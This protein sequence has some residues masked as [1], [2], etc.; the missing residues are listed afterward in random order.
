MEQIKSSSR[1]VPSLYFEPILVLNTCSR[2]AVALRLVAALVTSPHLHIEPFA[3]QVHTAAQRLSRAPRARPCLRQIMPA[4]ITCIVCKALWGAKER[5]AALRPSARPLVR[6]N[7]NSNRKPVSLTLS[8][9]LRCSCRYIR[10]SAVVLVVRILKRWR[11]LPH[12][13][14]RTM[15]T[16]LHA[17]PD[18]SKVPPCRCRPCTCA[19]SSGAALSLHLT[20]FLQPF[21]THFGALSA[22]STMS[23]H[24]TATLLLPHMRP[25]VPAPRPSPFRAKTTPTCCSR[26]RS[27]SICQRYSR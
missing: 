7:R 5:R 12:A 3:H 14:L 8:R 23:P 16:L 19:S 15:H 24:S 27:R 9:A 17:L 10:K 13:H 20:A 4:V 1:C 18:P 21:C 25:S 11:R 6:Q 22:I 2:L 26:W